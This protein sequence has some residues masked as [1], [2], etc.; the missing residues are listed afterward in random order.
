MPQLDPA[1]VLNSCMLQVRK[2][3]EG[4]EAPLYVLLRR[5]VQNN[6]TL[7]P[8][9]PSKRAIDPKVFHRQELEVTEEDDGPPKIVPL[10][11]MTPEYEVRC[12]GDLG[13]ASAV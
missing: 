12:Y 5:W 3:F 8:E 1:L 2:D 6:P 4:M 13:D 9:F 11:S 7:L 10:L